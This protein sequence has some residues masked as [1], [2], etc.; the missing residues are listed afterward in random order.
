[1]VPAASISL[2]TMNGINVATSAAGAN[3]DSIIQNY[4]GAVDI[5]PKHFNALSNHFKSSN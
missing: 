3:M 1:M 2:L 5:S 4:P